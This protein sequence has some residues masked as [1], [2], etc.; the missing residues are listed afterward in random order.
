MLYCK[1]LLMHILL[2]CKILLVNGK[3]GYKCSATQHNMKNTA[4][5]T[6]I[7]RIDFVIN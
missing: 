4:V 7:T 1:H 3:P 2:H 6:N 5:T